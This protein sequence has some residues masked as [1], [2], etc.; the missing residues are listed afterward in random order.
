MIVHESTTV[1]APNPPLQLTPLRVERDRGV[2]D[3]RKRSN[4]VPIY[5]CGAAEWQA[6]RRQDTSLRHKPTMVLCCTCDTISRTLIMPWEPDTEYNEIQQAHR[7]RRQWWRRSS[8]STG[9]RRR[10]LPNILAL[11]LFCALLA[12]PLS[13]L[14]I[15]YALIKPPCYGRS[16][17]NPLV[18]PAYFVMVGIQLN[19]QNPLVYRI[20]FGQHHPLGQQSF[21]SESIMAVHIPL[22]QPFR[23][24]S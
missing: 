23:C 6:V 19:E 14:A 1:A 20:E 18:Q 11:V 15:H 13:L 16:F 17:G 10:V 8:T 12:C 24:G 7:Q 9:K 4:V 3:T 2:F 21:S 5:R 22:N